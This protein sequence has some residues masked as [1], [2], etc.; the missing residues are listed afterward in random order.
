MIA[1]VHMI[2]RSDVPL[3]EMQDGKAKWHYDTPHHVMN[4]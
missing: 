1:Q 3:T 4:L 2:K